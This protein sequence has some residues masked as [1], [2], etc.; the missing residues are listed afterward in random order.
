LRKLPVD[1]GAARPRHDGK[2]SVEHRALGKILVEPKIHQIAKYAAALRDAK[3]QR[4]ANAKSLLRRQRI[5]LGFVS[6][7]RD[8][9]ADRCKADTHHDRVARPIDELVDRATVK[10]R[11]G[12]PRNLDMAVIDETPGETGRRCPQIGLVADLWVFAAG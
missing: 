1:A 4:S 12:R 5:A 8:D 2:D 7:E 10:P 6:Q 9:V 11:G 3:T